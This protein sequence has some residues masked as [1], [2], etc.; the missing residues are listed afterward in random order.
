MRKCKICGG[1]ARAQ[2]SGDEERPGDCNEGIAT[3]RSKGR[4]H[5][6]GARQ[7][8]ALRLQVEDKVE[9]AIQEV[10]GHIRTLK[11]Q[12][13]DRIGQAI[14][15]DHPIIHW[16]LEYAAKLINRVRVINKK[17]TP[18]EAIRSKH[19]GCRMEKF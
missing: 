10:D 19:T 1:D 7:L 11:L 5:R 16:M 8:E 6:D 18:R 15:P 14:P 17:V 9:E 4:D 13:E 3:A 12:T 2:A